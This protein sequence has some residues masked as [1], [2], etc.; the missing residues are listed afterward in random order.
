[1]RARRRTMASPRAEKAP[2]SARD[3][4]ANKAGYLDYPKAISSG[5]PIAAGVIE[6]AVRHVCKDRM[7]LTGSRWGLN[8]AEAILKLRALRSNGNWES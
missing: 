7:V 8:G 6:G 1:M 3:N 4:L 5:W 2:T